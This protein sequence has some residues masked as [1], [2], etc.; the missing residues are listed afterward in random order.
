VI[1]A[2]REYAGWLGYGHPERAQAWLDRLALNGPEIEA[3]RD[4]PVTADMPY[5]AQPTTVA[6]AD[7]IPVAHEPTRDV[8]AARERA[9]KDGNHAFTY[10]PKQ[11]P[12]GIPM[13]VK[14][15][16]A[17]QGMPLTGGSKAIGAQ[18]QS[19]DAAVV[20]RLRDAGFVPIG[21]A[22]LHEFAYGI[23]SANP[24][25]GA[26]VNPAAPDRIPGGSS[27]GSAAAVA[28]RRAPGALGSDT[29]GSIR[30]PAAVCGVVGL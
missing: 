26:V 1:D 20:R 2:L 30:Q 18:V 12:P 7:G 21:L 3:F 29:G 11:V 19:R 13:A 5:V 14:D 24:H 8:E 25:F 6:P 23:T 15:L 4:A 17:V 27:G 9:A 22:N 28:A 16:M 10:V